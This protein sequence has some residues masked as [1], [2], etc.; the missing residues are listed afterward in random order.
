MGR[1]PLEL[2]RELRLADRDLPV[3]EAEL[4]LILGALESDFAVAL[5]N[6]GALKGRL[7]YVRDIALLI[8]GEMMVKGNAARGAAGASARR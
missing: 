8:Q 1:H 2:E 7:S 4:R 5:D 6:D 3:E